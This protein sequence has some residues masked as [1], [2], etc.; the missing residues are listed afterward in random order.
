MK[1]K[2]L[3]VPKITR[4][5]IEFGDRVVYV[6]GEEAERWDAMIKQQ[7]HIAARYGYVAPKINWK[8]SEK[9][10]EEILKNIVLV[11]RKE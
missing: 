6:D 4:V 7:A 11:D 3:L 10:S 5:I 8:I 1:N 2:S 9:P